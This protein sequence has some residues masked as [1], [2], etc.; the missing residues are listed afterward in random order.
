MSESESTGGARILLDGVTKRY[1]AQSQA[2]VDDITVTF[3]GIGGHAAHPDRSI[4]PV[5]VAA[6]RPVMRFRL[7]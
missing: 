2:A 6:N 7:R 4:D 1:D 3:H 5:P